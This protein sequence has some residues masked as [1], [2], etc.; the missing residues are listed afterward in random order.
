MNKRLSKM[1]FNLLK[2]F[3]STFMAAM[4]LMSAPAHAVDGCKI[5]LCMAG[6]WRNIAECEPEVRKALKDAARGKTWPQCSMA[7][8]NS[9]GSSPDAAATMAPAYAPSNCPA[10]YTSTVD[11]GGDSGGIAYACKYSMVISVS[12]QGQPW[13]RVWSDAEGNTSTEYFPA[14]K[15][16]LKPSDMDPT[17]DSD[18]VLYQAALEAEAAAK[19]AAAQGGDSGG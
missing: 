5:M 14:A 16:Q 1:T 9:S 6:N 19:A 18:Y 2:V 4:A 7:S 12:I 13:T 17:F 8:S 10:Q 11:V 15:A 3:L